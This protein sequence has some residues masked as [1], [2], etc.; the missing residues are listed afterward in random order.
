MES[1]TPIWS[2]YDHSNDLRIFRH[3]DYTNVHISMFSNGDYHASFSQD[4]KDIQRHY[5][6]VNRNSFQIDGGTK[7]REFFN[8]FEKSVINDEIPLA[9]S[10]YENLKEKWKRE[11]RFVSPIE[12]HLKQKQRA[13]YSPNRSKLKRKFKRKATSP[14]IRETKYKRRNTGI[15]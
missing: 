2:F 8:A 7:L 11:S 3:T 1:T 15:D 5:G 9:K 14:N 10:L 6:Y 13:K 4:T 12:E